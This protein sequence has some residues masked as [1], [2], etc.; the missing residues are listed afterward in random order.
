MSPLFGGEFV[1][2]FLAARIALWIWRS[3]AD[4]RAPAN[5]P[6]PPGPPGGGRPQPLLRPARLRL[7]HTAPAAERAVLPRAA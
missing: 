6:G 4:L 5:D 3:R 1:I 7:V 2:A